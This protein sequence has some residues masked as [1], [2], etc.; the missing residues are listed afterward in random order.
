ML[1]VIVERQPATQQGPDIT[2]PLIV[3][4][5]V[6]GERGRVEC[7]RNATNREFVD[8]SG[9]VGPF[10]APGA[11]LVVMDGE[12]Q[13]WRGML[14]SLTWS[15]EIDGENFSAVSSMRIEREVVGDAG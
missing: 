8:L 12:Q 10:M 5:A 14:R 3:N 2:S 13:S 15:I 4:Q 1:S 6:A 7:D 9:P 11:M